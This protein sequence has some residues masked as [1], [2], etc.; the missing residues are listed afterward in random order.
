MRQEEEGEPSG[1]GMIERMVA[2]EPVEPHELRS[3]AQAMGPAAIDPLLDGLTL[4]GSREIRLCIL[5]CLEALGEEARE[6]ALRRVPHAPWYVTRNLLALLARGPLPA[7]FDPY[8]FLRAQDARVRVEAVA[9]ARQLP[10]PTPALALALSDVDPR[11]VTSALRS[12]EALV[13]TALLQPLH[14]IAAQGEIEEMRVQAT[15]AIG[16]C[17]EPEALLLLVELTGAK[18]GLL[19]GIRFPRP[20]PVMLEAVRGLAFA[21]V[22]GIPLAGVGGAVLEAAL[23]SRDRVLQSVAALD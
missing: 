17:P 23:R 1:P 4:S 11:V 22:A 14:R 8:P 18:R 9:V 20:T 15:R 5:D 7:G 19:G 16:R 6:K 2:G 12:L 21:R 3:A 13:P 10:D